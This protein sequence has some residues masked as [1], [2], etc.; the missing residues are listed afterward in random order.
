MKKDYRKMTH[1]ELSDYVMSNPWATPLEY[2]LAHR[3]YALTLD[4]PQH[5]RKS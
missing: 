4:E 2:H 1:R 3:L 5:L